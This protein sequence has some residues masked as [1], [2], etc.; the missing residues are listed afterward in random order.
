MKVNI[1]N[2]NSEAL[3]T[4]FINRHYLYDAQQYNY[5]FLERKLSDLFTILKI[6]CV[7][8]IIKIAKNNQLN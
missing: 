2:M 5:K 6:L 3:L 4:D 8:K 7:T 1:V